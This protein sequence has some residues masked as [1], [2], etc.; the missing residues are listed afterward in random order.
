MSKTIQTSSGGIF[1]A[2][3]TAELARLKQYFPYRIVWG[4]IDADTGEFYTGADCDRRKLNAFLRKKP[5]NIVA[6]FG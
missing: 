2:E 5:G 1:T 3:Q 4:G 6:T